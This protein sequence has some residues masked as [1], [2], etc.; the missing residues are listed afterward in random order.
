MQIIAKT[1]R[2]WNQVK[3]LYLNTLSAS[4]TYG[5][6]ASFLQVLAS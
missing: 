3:G 4:V 1:R 6:H 2:E 5:N